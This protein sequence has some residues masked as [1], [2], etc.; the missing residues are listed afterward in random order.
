MLDM[1]DVVL[2]PAIRASHI[3]RYST[4]P[5]N[6][7]ESV[8]EHS[9]YVAFFSMLV[10]DDLMLVDSKKLWIHKCAL[11]HDLEECLTGDFLRSFKYSTSELKE[12]LDRGALRAAQE[13]FIDI[14]DSQAHWYVDAWKNAKDDSITGNIVRYADFL[15]V[16]AY[17]SKESAMGNQYAQKM[18]NTELLTY[19]NLFNAPEFVIFK[20]YQEQISHI[21]QD[22]WQEVR[23]TV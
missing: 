1:N 16:V 5:V 23:V 14:F 11:V 9:F 10:A 4:I 13:T 22:G 2:G 3:S 15:S 12:A 20:D 21:L 8:A 6:H 18:V 19:W 7:R 17:L